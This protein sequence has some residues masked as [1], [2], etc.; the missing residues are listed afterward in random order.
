M[1]FINAKE[2]WDTY[3]ISGIETC[4]YLANRN[5]MFSQVSLCTENE[6]IK[7]NKN[8]LTPYVCGVAG[9]DGR[10]NCTYTEPYGSILWHTH[11]SSSKPYPSTEDIVKSL[12]PRKPRKPGEHEQIYSCILVC[13]WGVWEWRASDKENYPEK[14]D[15]D[16]DDDIEDINK[17]IT[18]KH[19]LIAKSIG[20]DPFTGHTKREAELNT[21]IEIAIDNFITDLNNSLGGMGFKIYFTSW[22]NIKGSSFYTLNFQ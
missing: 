14:D 21:T 10:P 6:N 22:K 13:F 9:N 5:H 2:I 17:F 11:P 3:N 19:K 1:L 18:E 7:E 20:Q 4:G 12:K 15:E 16:Y 8:E